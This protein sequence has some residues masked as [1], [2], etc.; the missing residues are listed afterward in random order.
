MSNL[1]KLLKKLEQSYDWDLNDLN[2]NQSVK[3]VPPT[4]ITEPLVIDDE[5]AAGFYSRW[6]WTPIFDDDSKQI[7]YI[8]KLGY[9]QKFLCLCD[10]H[11]IN[12]RAELLDRKSLCFHHD[13]KDKMQF[14]KDALKQCH[15]SCAGIL[16][17]KGNADIEWSNELE[18]DNAYG[19]KSPS[20]QRT[21]C[22]DCL[23]LIFQQSEYGS[24]MKHIIQN[25][26]HEYFNKQT[27][28]IY[29]M[30]N[31]EAIFIYLHRA[32]NTL[33][34]VTL[35]QH[36]SFG[37]LLCSKK[38]TFQKM[39][40]ILFEDLKFWD[41]VHCK[42]KNYEKLISKKVK[43][44]WLLKDTMCDIKKL[45]HLLHMFQMQTVLL[46]RKKYRC[47]KWFMQLKNGLYF[48]QHVVDTFHA[49]IN[50]KQVKQKS[51]NHTIHKKYPFYVLSI[52]KIKDIRK[53]PKLMH[54]VNN[55]TDLWYIISKQVSD[56]SIVN[57]HKR[58][59]KI[60]CNFVECK[61]DYYEWKYGCNYYDMNTNYYTRQN[62]KCKEKNIW[63]QPAINKW[64][65]CKGCRVVFYCS[66]RCQK[67]DWS[68]GLHKEMCQ[69]IIPQIIAGF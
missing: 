60:S 39:L 69:Q 11:F 40:L 3:S 41:F 15:N 24:Y 56:F 34:Y 32:Y 1:A 22:V 27:I 7:H 9:F 25:N 63:Q 2:P 48:R 14:I 42:W 17:S 37:R 13:Y 28:N 54:F 64:Y 23:L 50:H 38:K 21:I 49:D 66:R 62:R 10:I 47:L 52:L 8:K 45:I 35:Y 20:C 4:T 51:N 59:N 43:N 57:N 33:L 31:S 67:A 5:W 19:T 6:N 26:N 58:Y 68:K 36:P 44:E 46:F 12:E 65:K 55:N 61:H 18:P 29:T 53:Y 30:F 16:A